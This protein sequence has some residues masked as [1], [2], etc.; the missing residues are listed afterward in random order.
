M[1]KIIL[2]IFMICIMTAGILAHNIEV[3]APSLEK[4]F[5]KIKSYNSEVT[6]YKTGY[7]CQK[8]A[9]LKRIWDKR[10]ILSK[11]TY[12]NARH[13]HQ[14]YCGIIYEKK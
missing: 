9:L 8:A 4:D 1:N 10:I 12:K 6:M 5:K 13:P 11:I 3:G 2:G 14:E 7:N